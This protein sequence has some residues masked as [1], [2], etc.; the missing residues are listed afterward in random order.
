MRIALRNAPE[1]QMAMPEG[2][3]SVRIDRDT[4][5]PARAGQGNAIFET[6][7][8]ERVPTCDAVVELPNIFND[9]TGIDEPE[10]DEDEPL[11]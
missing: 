11:F 6:F 5:C 10:T 2:I 7:R 4:G 8:E 3:V 1:H 9:T